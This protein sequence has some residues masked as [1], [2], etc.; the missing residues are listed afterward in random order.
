MGHPVHFSCRD[1]IVRVRVHLSAIS[2]YEPLYEGSLAFQ[3]PVSPASHRAGH[4]PGPDRAPDQDLVPE[5]PHE[6]QEGQTRGRSGR[7]I[8][9]R[10]RRR[11]QRLSHFDDRRSGAAAADVVRLLNDDDGGGGGRRDSH[12]SGPF[13]DAQKN[14]HGAE[15]N[16]CL[17]SATH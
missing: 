16:Y 12:D 15:V 10:R 17:L 1:Y 4:Q 5:P 2:E 13:E 7:R 8:C 14:G 11:R 6:G 3:V 9:R